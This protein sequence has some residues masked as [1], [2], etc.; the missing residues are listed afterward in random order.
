MT[1]E[2]VLPCPKK[3]YSSVGDAHRGIGK[4]RDNHIIGKHK[5]MRAY[6]CGWCEAITGEKTW[7]V[8]SKRDPKPFR[9]L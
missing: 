6:Q 7:H 8:T 3:A 5:K 4:M 1:V 9:R 2:T